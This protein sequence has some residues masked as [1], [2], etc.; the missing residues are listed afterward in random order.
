MVNVMAMGK[1][2]KVLS[3][4][5]IRTSL[6][7]LS[8]TRNSER[9]I[10]ILLLSVKA[11]LRAKE[12]ASLT[13]QMLTD[14]EGNISDTIALQNV[15]SKGKHG[16]RSIPLNKDLKAALENLKVF[17][18]AKRLEKGF[19]F[20]LASNVVTSE[21]GERMSANSIAHW[22]K[23][24]YGNLGFDGCSSHSGR[25]TAITRWAKGVS[26][27]GGSL[28]DVQELSG[29]ASLATTQRYIQSDSASK[30]KLVD[31]G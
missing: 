8:M 26:K 27:V 21:R 7:F 19:S 5:Q 29:H 9:D 4:V 15:A 2:A 17:A 13:W 3:E 20:D 28:K 22:F 16:G 25:R 11:G 1:Q 23:R 31:C 12:I 6:Q 14:P 10:V 18:A 30:R 24:L